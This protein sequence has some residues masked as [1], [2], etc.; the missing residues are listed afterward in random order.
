MIFTLA[1]SNWI[2]QIIEMEP[3]LKQAL[4]LKFSDLL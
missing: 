1:Q 3:R 2:V 4:D